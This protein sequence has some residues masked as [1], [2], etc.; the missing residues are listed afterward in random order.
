[1]GIGIGGG[2]GGGNYGG[3]GHQSRGRY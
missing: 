2:Y 3:G 1:V